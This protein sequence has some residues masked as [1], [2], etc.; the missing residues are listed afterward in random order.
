MSISQPDFMKLAEA[1]G[2]KGIRAES[3][4]DVPG[5]LKDMME[6]DGPVL[7]DVLADRLENVF[8]MIPAGAAVKDMII[9]RPKHKMEKPE[10]ST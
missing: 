3:P 10:G 2:I 7:L 9:E 1:Y 5:A 4:E 8:P 6:S